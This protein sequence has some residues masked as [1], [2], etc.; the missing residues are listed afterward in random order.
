MGL[1][2]EAFLGHLATLTDDTFAKTLT[3]FI[4]SPTLSLS[5]LFKQSGTSNVEELLKFV[6]DRYLHSFKLATDAAHH[7]SASVRNRSS[8]FSGVPSTGAQRAGERRQQSRSLDS[9]PLSR[10]PATSRA[11]DEGSVLP[12][13]E[14]A[15]PPTPPQQ[16][17]VSALPTPPGS[18]E[19]AL[20]SPK[21]EISEPPPALEEG[22]EA[23]HIAALPPSVPSV[24]SP[25]SQREENIIGPL[26][27][28]AEGS[29]RGVETAPLSPSAE[30][31]AEESVPRR[32][33]TI[34]EGNE[35]ALYA[36]AETTLKEWV[37]QYAVAIKEAFKE[38][39]DPVGQALYGLVEDKDNKELMEDVL[40]SFSLED[41]THLQGELNGK[42]LEGFRALPQGAVPEFSVPGNDQKAQ[43][44]RY[45][46]QLIL[47]EREAVKVA[48]ADAEEDSH[49]AAARKIIQ[50]P[51][52]Q[53][54]LNVLL[55]R[56]VDG[57]PLNVSAQDI[58]VNF[59][60]ELLRGLSNKVFY[61][62]DLEESR[63][64]FPR[65]DI[66]VD[67][68]SV[69]D[70]PPREDFA[71][72]PP[73]EPFA[74]LPPRD[75]SLDTPKTREK[76]AEEKAALTIQDFIHAH[77]AILKTQTSVTGG[78]LN[79]YIRQKAVELDK[80][81]TDLAQ[82]LIENEK[83]QLSPYMSAYLRE[84]FSNPDDVDSLTDGCIQELQNQGLTHVE[85]DIVASY[86]Q[87]AAANSADSKAKE[88]FDVI[89][90][91]LTQNFIEALLGEERPT[92]KAELKEWAD[93][94]M[95]KAS[96]HPDDVNHL[97]DEFINKL[98]ED[99]GWTEVPREIVQYTLQSAVANPFFVSPI[100]KLLKDE[101]VDIADQEAINER[102][103]ALLP[104]ASS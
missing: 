57:L 4:K 88:N 48:F 68:A 36:Q 61:A 32:L 102:L 3:E 49:N 77:K 59:Y 65:E 16:M 73:V 17:P 15:L 97:T 103:K 40:D 86:L 78:E 60:Q 46:L 64:R 66:T 85:R 56:L 27:E 83:S 90:G 87:A 101:G 99:L 93:E 45:L 79:V 69:P 12:P 39:T 13:E 96:A 41:P 75:L 20:T 47:Q 10:L 26:F 31:R 19:A 30:I 95:Q 52:N 53:E 100:I 94:Y 63:P 14:I 71:T 74:S 84:A 2:Q 50:Q 1:Q 34:L 55:E 82:N 104:K 5:D 51:L 29:P 72:A 44:K 42:L 21:E 28:A 62:P 38:A 24:E 11:S 37:S 6:Q 81:S 35:E 8:S 91:G 80:L 22:E 7:G 58:A 89:V 54:D 70:S 9:P 25:S 76:T 23:A 92:V 98:Q 18:E 67:A 33:S 43:T